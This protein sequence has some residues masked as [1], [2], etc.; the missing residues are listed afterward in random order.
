MSHHDVKIWP[1][2]YG[3]VRFG[4]KNF[5]VRKNDRDYRAGDTIT[6]RE[7]SP[8]TRIIGGQGYEYNEEVIGFTNADPLGPY[9]IGYVLPIDAKR[10]VFSLLPM[11]EK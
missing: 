11:G 4:L 10:V 5:E 9:R 2:Y 7:W 1:E 8:A 3:L 6:M